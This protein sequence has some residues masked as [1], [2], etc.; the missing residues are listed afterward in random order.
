MLI[1][2]KNNI[3]YSL[4]LILIIVFMGLFM[5]FTNIAFADDVNGNLDVDYYDK[6]TIDLG[7]KNDNSQNGDLECSKELNTNVDP[8]SGDV[9]I[10]EN[11]ILSNTTENNLIIV[12]NISFKPHLQNIDIDQWEIIDK[13]NSNI[14]FRGSLNDVYT[15]NITLMHSSTPGQK[16][17]ST[18]LV[19]K[20]KLSGN[21]ALK[22]ANTTPFY[23]EYSYESQAKT[24]KAVLTGSTLTFYY[25]YLSHEQD[26]LVYKIDEAGNK[27]WGEV[28]NRINN[29]NFDISFRDFCPSTCKEWFKDFVNLAKVNN[30]NNLNFSKLKNTDYM[31]QGCINLDNIDMSSMFPAPNIVESSRFMFVSCIKLNSFNISNWFVSNIK[32]FKAMFAECSSAT[33]LDV[34]RWDTSSGTDFSAMFD[35]CLSLQNVPCENFNVTN[36][37]D[38]SWLFYCCY[39]LK[40]VDLSKWKTPNVKNISDMF[41]YNHELLEIKGLS[42]LDTSKVTDMSGVFFECF[43]IKNLDLSSWDTSNV[44][45]MSEALGSDNRGMFTSCYALT[46]IK[47]SDKFVTTKTKSSSEMFTH[48][49]SLVGGNGTRYSLSFTDKTYARIDL[50]S[51]KGYFTAAT[52]STNNVLD[53]SSYVIDQSDA[54]SKPDQSDASSSSDQNIDMALGNSVVKFNN[55][56]PANLCLTSGNQAETD[57]YLSIVEDQSS[58]EKQSE[59]QNKENPQAKAS[60]KTGELIPIVVILGCSMVVLFS[61][62]YLARKLYTNRQ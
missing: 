53:D 18:E 5:L 54:S 35:G 46:T 58:K 16:G 50:P 30:I 19:V 3:K 37:T 59:V 12:N 14:V 8:K 10:K 43:K 62:V 4:F 31:F 47:A 61:V 17:E 1:Y 56:K 9:I 26:G 38:L 6:N 33:N 13:R 52:S 25:D 36:A 7:H 28:A 45:K 39:K 15:S 48:C 34:S 55:F 2:F 41:C 11:I 57:C 60:S 22:L 32:D 51:R 21:N 40:S 44:E 27:S 23:I 29:V 20:T 42:S 24:P 49:T